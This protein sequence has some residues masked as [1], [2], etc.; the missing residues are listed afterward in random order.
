MNT[1]ILLDLPLKPPPRRTPVRSAKGTLPTRSQP[2]GFRVRAILGVLIVIG[3][4][5][6][7]A[8]IITAEKS[9]RL[10]ELVQRSLTA[11]YRWETFHRVD[12]PL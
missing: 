5:A 2:R 4:C 8:G 7:V 6:W 11:T 12:T 3:A 10:G 9:L 1:G